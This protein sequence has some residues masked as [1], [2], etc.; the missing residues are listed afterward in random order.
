[1]I[2]NRILVLRMDML[3]DIV[4]SLPAIKALKDSFPEAQISVLVKKSFS[5]LLKNLDYIDEIIGYSSEWTVMRKINFFRMLKKRKYDLAIDLAYSKD[6]KSALF[7]FLSGA[8][9]RA[10]YNTGIRG[11]FLNK[12]LPKIKELLY[13]TDYALRAVNDIGAKEN[14]KKIKLTLNKKAKE[15]INNFWKKNKLNQKRVVLLAPGASN[16]VPFKAWPKERFAQLADILIEK[17][18]VKIILTG[19]KKEKKLEQDIVKLMRN[20]PIEMTGKL[21]LDEFCA[22]LKK[23]NLLICN[24][25][26]PMHLTNTLKIPSI[27]IS[28]PSSRIRWGEG[29]KK[30]TYLSK[31]M[32]CA[33]YDC[34]DCQRGDYECIRGIKLEEVLEAVK[35]KLK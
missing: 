29:G 5:S 20:R 33:G 13:E 23:S 35:K 1:M 30:A 7:S 28:G 19:S 21:E 6:V 27:V 11:F 26:G 15:T 22:L 17:Y 31:K 10:G 12:K 18:K 2:P 9:I 16:T 14:T 24:N 4:L 32:E 3:G 8:K 34:N 25:T